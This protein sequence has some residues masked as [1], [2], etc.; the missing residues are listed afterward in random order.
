MSLIFLSH[1]EEDKPVMEEISRGLEDSG[2]PTWYFERDTL[3]GTSYLLQITRAIEEC[4]AVILI[5]SKEAIDSDQV[6][7]EIIGA[8]ERGIPFFPVLTD[9]TPPQLKEKQPEWRH[10][11]GGTAMVCLGE[12]GITPTVSSIIEG[13]KARDIHPG[14]VETPTFTPVLST[15]K[16]DAPKHLTDRVLAERASMEGERKQV[17]VLSAGITVPSSIDPEE[18]HEILSPLSDLM[19]DEVRR[20]EGTIANISPEGLTAIFGAPIAHEDDPVRALIAALAIKRHLEERLEKLSLRAGVNTGLVIVGSIADDLSMEYT[21]IGDTV[22][23]ASQM[24]DAAESGTILASEDTRDL[25]GGYFE[26]EDAGELTAAGG[27]IKTYRVIEATHAATRVEA[28]LAKGLSHFVGREKELAH[29]SE[30]LDKASAGQGQVIGVVGE[31]GVGKSRLILEFTRSLSPEEYTLLQGGCYHYGEAIPFLPIIELLKGYFGIE[32]TDDHVT[33]RKKMEERIASFT[34]QLDEA[35]SPVCELLSLPVEDEAYQALEPQQRRE[36]LISAVRQLLATESQRRPLVLVIEDLHW[37]DRTSEDFISSLIDGITNSRM[38]LILLYRSEYTSPWTSKS[39]YSTLRVDQLPD[40]TSSELISSILS[41]GEVSQEITDLIATKSSGNPLFIEELTHG[42]LENGSIVKEDHLYTLTG[43][44]SDLEVPDTIQGIIASRLDR[45]AED[46]KRLMQA[47]SVI[48]R[49][50]AYRLLEAI[51][52]MQEELKSSLSDLQE[53]ELIYEK[54]LFPELA[55]IFKHALTQ[56]VAYNSLLKK[57]RRELHGSIGAA[58]EALYP[59]RLE[60]LY[61]VLAYHYARS[62]YADKAIHYLKLSGDK[63]MRNYSNWEAVRFYREA[64]RILDSLPDSEERKREKIEVYFSIWNPMILLNYPEGSLEV[65]EE[66]ERLA[67]ELD[68]GE[69]LIRVYRRF[70]SYH[71]LSGNNS[72][73]MEYAEKCLDEAEKIGAVDSIARSA[74]AVGIVYFA[75]GDMSKAADITHRALQIIEE[76]NREKDI[77]TGGLNVYSQLCGY[78]GLALGWLGR[79]E[80]AKD[81]LGKGLVTARETNDIFGMGF[82]E[83]CHFPVCSFGEDGD[84]S[85]AHALKAIE[86]FEETGIEILLGWAWSFLSNGYYMLGQYETARDYGEKS[87]E[88]QEKAGLPYVL[89]V[90]YWVLA[91]VHLAMGNTRSAR[92]LSE[93]ALKVS[94]EFNAKN[95]E[96]AQWTMLGRIE[97]EENPSQVD[98]AEEHIRHGILMVDELRM[99][100]LVAW[101]YLCLGEVFALAGRAEDAIENLKIAEKMYQEMSMGYWLTRTQEALARLENA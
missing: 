73:G 21:A 6:T 10:A 50:F 74:N 95:Y 97:G 99:K 84:S 80:E 67:R 16:T 55:Y 66:V 14:E 17:T 20:Y 68:D 49:E 25:A 77:F 76:Q 92:A 15:P 35:M 4:D 39:Y 85:I 30:C 41:E 65:L 89:P 48:G 81:V 44:P 58:I 8:F 27:T 13:L 61:E 79:Y 5:V 88:L 52:Q 63:A 45:L 11:L 96:A 60:E 37:T 64:L 1:I 12:E 71:T 47:A 7:K 42:L 46:L 38:L 33:T 32:D 2:Y 24:K 59:D 18:L 31:A 93:E 82:I 53:S 3:P 70:A 28:S 94:R 43:K 98:V 9:V 51:T 57:K 91:L 29:L 22:S 83:Q 54:S 78:C 86:Y 101:G 40:K 23:M 62:D 26:F 87:L 56:E 19:S 100:P 90:I 69:S 36:R 75:A 34:G 72:L